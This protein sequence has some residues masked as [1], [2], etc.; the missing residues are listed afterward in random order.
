MSHTPRQ[1]QEILDQESLRIVEMEG[2]I[3]HFGEG[4][5][6]KMTDKEFESVRQLLR[7]TFD[8]V[9]EVDTVVP[10]DS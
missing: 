1:I 7:C 5:C 3:P 6:L 10:T 8:L 2:E 4:F 9:H